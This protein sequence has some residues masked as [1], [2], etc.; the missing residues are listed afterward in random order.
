MELESFI[1]FLGNCSFSL[2]VHPDYAIPL[3]SVTSSP[4]HSAC[5]LEL[6]IYIDTHLEKAWCSRKLTYIRKYK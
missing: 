4:R 6:S 2:L 1:Y 3:A 5:N